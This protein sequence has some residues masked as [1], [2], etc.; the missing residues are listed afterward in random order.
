MVSEA[1]T[2]AHVRLKALRNI[3][4]KNG[5]KSVY[6]GIDEKKGDRKMHMKRRTA[7][8]A[9]VLSAIFQ[10]CHVF[11]RTLSTPPQNNSITRLSFT[12]E[13]QS[14]LRKQRVLSSGHSR[15]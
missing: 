15:Y 8:A 14:K 5:T 6:F 1:H 3:A 13:A 4:T 9:P 7:N 12:Q 11:K 2:S 10:Y